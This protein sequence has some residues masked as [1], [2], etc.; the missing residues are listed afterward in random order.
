MCGSRVGRS[1]RFG[2]FVFVL[3]VTFASIKASG[4]EP[5]IFVRKVYSEEKGGEFGI[6]V[7]FLSLLCLSSTVPVVCGR[8]SPPQRDRVSLCPGYR[9]AGEK[10]GGRCQ[11]GGTQT[12]LRL[13]HGSLEDILLE[14]PFPSPGAVRTKARKNARGSGLL[15]LGRGQ[16]R[17]RAITRLAD[18]CMHFSGRPNYRTSS[19]V[20]R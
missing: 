9:P 19:F 11:P 8:C 1:P 3:V 12:S 6:V 16:K 13:L 7:V 2:Y 18:A 14:L 20:R 15:G 5:L 10:A 4:D 17:A